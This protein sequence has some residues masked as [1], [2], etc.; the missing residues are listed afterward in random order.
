[1][2]NSVQWIFFDMGSTLVDESEAYRRRIEDAIAGTGVSF[3]EFW[4]VMIAH[5][6]QNRKGD[7]EAV[8]QFGLRLT[9][10]HS[11]EERLYPGALACLKELHSRYH[12]GILAN[13]P[14]GARE[15]LQDFGILEH[16][17]LVVSSA[18]EGLSKPDPRFFELALKRAGCPPQ[19]AVMVGDRLDNDIAPAKRLGMK[20]LW[21]K[22]GFGGLSTPRTE[23]ERPDY[24]AESLG[25]ICEL[26]SV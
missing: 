15:R 24:S 26:F 13:Q 9:G 1:M 19:K 6:R 16:I 23:Q 20:T 8:R 2:R 17:D 3:Q 5:Y 4:D 22:Q 14:P 25:E 21:L 11:E 7:L 18:E 12:I 10:W